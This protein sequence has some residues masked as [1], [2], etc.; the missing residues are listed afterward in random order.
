MADD[1]C[2]PEFDPTPWDGKTFE[3]KDKKFSKASVFTFFYMPVNFGSVMR[4]LMKG[5]DAAGVGTPDYIGL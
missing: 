3:W 1:N 5:I 2:C 4:K